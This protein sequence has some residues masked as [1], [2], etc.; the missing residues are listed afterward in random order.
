MPANCAH[1]MPLGCARRTHLDLFDLSEQLLQVHGLFQQCRD[2]ELGF[3]Q[4]VRFHLRVPTRQRPV[5]NSERPR[6]A[7]SLINNNGPC[8][9]GPAARPA[10]RGSS[11]AGRQ[12][13]PAP[14]PR[15]S[16]TTLRAGPR[17]PPRTAPSASSPG[18]RAGTPPSNATALQAATTRFTLGKQQGTGIRRHTS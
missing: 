17:A 4:L 13:R 15:T 18:I 12:T 14:R 8:P 1:A 7:K 11:P 3:A 6:G 5:C 9:A 2:E 10:A 16:T